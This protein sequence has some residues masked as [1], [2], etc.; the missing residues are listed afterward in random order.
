MLVAI[1]LSVWLMARA[2]PTYCSIIVLSLAAVILDVYVH[3]GSCRYP[4]T[5]DSA[6]LSC[7]GPPE[8]GH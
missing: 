1:T 4:L 7:V 3:P 8:T 6:L 2:S 5:K